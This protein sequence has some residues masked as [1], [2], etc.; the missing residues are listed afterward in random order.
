MKINTKRS[1]SYIC[2]HCNKESEVVGITQKETRYYF[3]NLNTRQMEDFHGDESVEL[4]KLFCL[5]C[6]KEITAE[7]LS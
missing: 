5:N 2:V 1:K 6:N 3:W 4:Q 7:L